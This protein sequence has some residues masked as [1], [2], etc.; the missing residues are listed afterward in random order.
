[1][2]LASEA[3]RQSM[4]RFRP[5]IQRVALLGIEG[6]PWRRLLEHGDE[7]AF[8]ATLLIKRS[9]FMELLEPVRPGCC[10]VSF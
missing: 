8:L 5:R 9:A 7:D 1:M 6:S 3:L 4:Y 2:V 10:A